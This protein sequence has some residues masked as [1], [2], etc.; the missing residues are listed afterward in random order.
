MGKF[1]NWLIHKLGGC[2]RSELDYKI[3]KL[4]EAL[5]GLDGRMVVEK[6]F[7]NLNGKPHQKIVARI[8]LNEMEDNIV[9]WDRNKAY[10]E[11][12]L[13]EMLLKELNN[14]KFEITSKTTNRGYTTY[15]MIIDVSQ[16]E[17]MIVGADKYGE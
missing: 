6:S 8:S 12:T 2:T 16:P 5:L 11:K 13:K 14:Y 15:Y 9:S 10:L 1:K 17:V 3:Y 4:R 7:F